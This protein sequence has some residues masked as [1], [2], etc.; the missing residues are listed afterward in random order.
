[1][2]PSFSARAWISSGF[3][4]LRSRTS[5]P[6]SPLSLASSI[7]V[8]NTCAP[9]RANISAQ[10]RPMPCA[11]AVMR[12]FLPVRRSDMFFSFLWLLWLG[13]RGAA[14]L[15]VE[16]GDRRIVISPQANGGSGKKHLQRACRHRHGEARA[17]RHVLD[18]AEIFDE[19]F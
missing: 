5:H 2:V 1:M 18:D 11:A 15:R 3:V 8:A 12:I 19:N 17:A 14:D 13:Q 9:P 10:A 16:P 7:S 4:T 6:A